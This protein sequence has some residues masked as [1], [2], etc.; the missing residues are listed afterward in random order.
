MSSRRPE[1]G[2]KLVLRSLADLLVLAEP[3]QLRLWESAQVTVSQLRVLRVL[4]DQN[5]PLQAG[6]L[7]GLAG[8]SQASLSRLLMKLEERGLIHREIDREDRRRV[9]VALTA[10]GRALLAASTLWR[11]TEFER[12]AAAM[13]PADREVFVTATQAFTDRVR[14]LSRAA[15]GS[16]PAATESIAATRGRA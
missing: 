9:G 2:P 1:P 16:Q 3:L 6:R 13:R 10:A 4:S 8:V 15:A 11:G 5:A 7:A 14:L 12:A